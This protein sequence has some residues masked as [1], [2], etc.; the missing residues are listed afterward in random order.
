M[1][2]F[3]ILA[4]PASI[5]ALSSWLPLF[6]QYRAKLGSHPAVRDIS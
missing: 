2:L 1:D 5:P 3:L 4:P 6:P